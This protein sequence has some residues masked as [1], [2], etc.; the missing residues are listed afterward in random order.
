MTEKLYCEKSIRENEH[1]FYNHLKKIERFVKECEDMELIAN[2]EEAFD[3]MF[4]RIRCFISEALPLYKKWYM[5]D[6]DKS[7]RVKKKFVKIRKLLLD[8]IIY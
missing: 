5:P 1:I 8:K 4:D 7:E 6:D 3:L 2:H